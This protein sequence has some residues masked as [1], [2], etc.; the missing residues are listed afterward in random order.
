MHRR[1]TVV[2]PNWSKQAVS[3]QCYINKTGNHPDGA[4][5][6][7]TQTV[8]SVIGWWFWLVQ[9]HILGEI[10][11]LRCLFKDIFISNTLSQYLTQNETTSP[12]GKAINTHI[13]GTT[14]LSKFIVW[15]QVYI[16]IVL[17]EYWT[18]S[19]KTFPPFLLVALVLITII[20]I[21]GVTVEVG[22]QRWT[23]YFVFTTVWG[24]F[25]K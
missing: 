3:K 9:S 23:T 17:Q 19:L 15:V 8:E 24:I 7:E 11:V 4:N 1:L 13:Y 14:T 6:E 21:L 18:E 25:N 12:K 16:S 22:L 2:F 5:W 20:Y 10:Q